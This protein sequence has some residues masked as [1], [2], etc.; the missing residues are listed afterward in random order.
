MFVKKADKFHYVRSQ[1]I[2]ILIFLKF[3]FCFWT[4]LFIDSFFTPSFIASEELILT[5]FFLLSSSILQRYRFILSKL[6]FALGLKV[7]LIEM[8]FCSLTLSLGCSFVVRVDTNMYFRKNIF[9][10]KRNIKAEIR[11]QCNIFSLSIVSKI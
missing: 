1:F 3:F 4:L 10:R 9:N 5:D 8:C 11:M 7:G 2:Q 6:F